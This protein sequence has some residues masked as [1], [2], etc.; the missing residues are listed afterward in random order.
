MTNAIRRSLA[1]LDW[2]L[3]GTLLLMGFLPTV[4]TTV[5]IYFLGDMPADWGFNI[6]SQLAW[7]HLIY[8]VL[9][10]AIMLPLFYLIGKSLAD[11]SA[12]ENKVRTGLLTTLLLYA[13]VS[14]VVAVF[15]RPLLVMMNQKAELLGASVV[16][17][18]LETAASVL[19]T[20]VQFMVLVLV[21][22]KKESHL[23]GFLAVQMTLTIL[24][25]TFLVSQLPFSLNLGVTGIAI[26]NIA[27]NLLLLAASLGLYRREG[28]RLAGGGKLDLS[29]LREWLTVGGYSGLESLV[30]NLA[31]MFMVI[32]M[33][34]VVGEQGTFWVA[35][36]FIWG[37]LL[38]PV[39][40]LGQL[41]KRDCGE[42]GDEAIRQRSLGYFALT[43][44]IV[45][46]WLVSLPLWPLFIR[47]V[48]NV[49]MYQDVYRIALWS[50][51][52]YVLFAFNNVVD[53]IF[54]GIGKTSY[55]L[56]QSIAVNSVFYGSLFMLWRMGIY[57]P[58]LM[59]I[60]LMFAAG[61]AVDSLLTFGMFAW[62]LRRRG[63]TLFP[64]QSIPLPGTKSK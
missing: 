52:F 38:L 7:V 15:A 10:E 58:T 29:W 18:R 36:S 20:L 13:S 50:L 11:K 23:V 57:Q 6:A 14:I 47:R 48:M 16:Y 21:M 19:A 33:V 63:M 60:A 26:G 9:Q 51:G 30:R 41:V 32:R 22:I 25:D 64:S 28:Y 34:N 40:Q 27:V 46:V 55:M 3:F 8:E 42:H 31:F 44:I 61:I 53:S 35:N 49:G 62:M 2:R 24:S 5:R 59:R 54:Y 17:I 56:F 37:W 43:G 45:L 39:L 4:Y 1:S 12:F